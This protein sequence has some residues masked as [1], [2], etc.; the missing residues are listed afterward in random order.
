MMTNRW[1]V[2][3]VLGASSV[4]F[5]GNRPQ[6]VG[7]AG[8]HVGHDVHSGHHRSQMPPRY[9]YEEREVVI[10]AEYRMVERREW[11]EPVYETRVRRVWVENAGCDRPL[12]IRIGR[13]KIGL[14]RPNRSRGYFKNVRE[15][16]CVQEGYYRTVQERVC[17][18]PERI[19]IVRDRVLVSDGPWTVGRKARR[20]P[21]CGTGVKVRGPRY[22]RY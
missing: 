7:R 22:P 11:V 20:G 15:R 8:R 3:M 18:S 5:A 9:E 16:V 13:V 6:G 2:L 12:G 1:T 4:A 14:G 21:R 17:V 19:E 10:P